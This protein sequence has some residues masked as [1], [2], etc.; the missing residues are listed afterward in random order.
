MEPNEQ[1]QRFNIHQLALDHGTAIGR[2]LRAAA[3]EAF[4]EDPDG[5]LER[6]VLGRSERG[7]ELPADIDTNDPE[8]MADLIEAGNAFL[9]QTIKGIVLAEPSN[10]V[11]NGTPSRVFEV[12]YRMLSHATTIQ[13]VQQGWRKLAQEA[14]VA[15]N[16]P[17]GIGIQTGELVQH[18]PS[19]PIARA[20]GTIFISD[21]A[22]QDLN[23]EWPFVVYRGETEIT[24]KR[25]GIEALPC[26]KEIEA[27]ILSS[28]AS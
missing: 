17:D 22:N 16:A 19:D 10:E 20:S 3:V 25:P 12:L 24:W 1:K 6:D 15:D 5:W 14:G 9:R 11:S 4:F 21:N 27:S 2:S 13:L 8:D 28:L 26:I 7:E 23:G 18:D